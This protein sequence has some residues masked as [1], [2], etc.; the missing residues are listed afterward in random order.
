VVVGTG[1]VCRW[2]YLFFSFLFSPWNSCWS[3]KTLELSFDLWGFPLWF[4]FFWFIIF[5]LGLYVKLWF[6]FNCTL[7]SLFVICCFFS[8]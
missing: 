8:I 1:T 2:R 7:Q 6:V 3:W 5:V 4:L